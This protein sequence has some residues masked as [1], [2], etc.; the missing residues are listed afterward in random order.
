M[1]VLKIFHGGDTLRP[2]K[3]GK[4]ITFMCLK[5]NNEVKRFC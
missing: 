1:V 3:C 5:K 4:R 2:D